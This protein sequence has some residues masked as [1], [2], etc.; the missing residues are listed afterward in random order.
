MKKIIIISFL[1][2]VVFTVSIY[3]QFTGYYGTINKKPA[4]DGYENILALGDQNDDGYDDYLICEGNFRF[5]TLYTFYFYHGG[6]V[7]DTIPYY[8][9]SIPFRTTTG[10]RRVIATDVNKDGWKDIIVST[11]GI[12]SGAVLLVCYGGPLLDSIPNQI[13]KRPEGSSNGWGWDVELVKDFDGDGNEELACYDPF[14]RYS[15]DQHW[16]TIYF[17]KIHEGIIDTIPFKIMEGDTITER[18]LDRIKCTDIN[19]DGLADIVIFGRKF[20]SDPHYF[21]Q[22]YLGN[23]NWDI[24]LFAQEIQ[25]Y[26]QNEIDNLIKRIYLPDINL[27]GK[28]DV[29]RRYTGEPSWHKAALLKGGF[30]IDTTIKMTMNTANIYITDEV[31]DKIDANGDGVPDLLMKMYGLGTH[32]TS[33]W[34]GSSSF[35]EYPVKQWYPID[36]YEGAKSGNIGDVNGD[37]ADDIYIGQTDNN[38]TI[39]YPGKVQIFLG[40]T[41]VHVPITRIEEK[42]NEKPG[43]YELLTVHPNPFNPETVISYQLPVNSKVILGIYDILGREVG[44]LVDEEQEAGKH[45]VRFNGTGLASGVYIVRCSYRQSDGLEVI[46]SLKIELVK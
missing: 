46:N 2:Q 23:S 12:N 22:I 39:N 13:A 26:T 30:P 21:N 29:I 17:H 20:G 41:S 9:F 18:R 33:L 11:I 40:D 38:N 34:L 6:P 5:D 15:G 37:G 8:K 44:K 35:N 4:Y 19:L 16:G 25:G 3:S 42:D 36:Q 7:I 27:D 24:S 45:E 14:T 1:I 43:S 10:P 28:S 31:A 32:R